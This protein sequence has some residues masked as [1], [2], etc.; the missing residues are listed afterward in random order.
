MSAE[1]RRVVEVLS[2]RGGVVELRALKN[3]SSAA[4]YFND[5]SALGREAAKLD[6]QGFAVYITANPTNPAL[7][8][9][10]ENRIKRPLREA[11]A[12]RDIDRRRWL[13]VD[14]DPV[15]PA[16]VSSTDEE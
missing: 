9:R 14:V 3:G 11:T 10:A 4:G 12:D 16:G 5:F 6:E 7:L 1:I 13:L 8:A 2:E 15:R